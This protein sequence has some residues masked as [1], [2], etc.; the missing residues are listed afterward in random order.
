[1]H[2][3]V[4]RM[5]ITMWITCGYCVENTKN[6]YFIRHI[7]WKSYSQN[8]SCIPNI[9]VHIIWIQEDSMLGGYVYKRGG[10]YYLNV[11]IISQC[12]YIDSNFMYQKHFKWLIQIENPKLCYKE[13]YLLVSGDNLDISQYMFAT[14]RNKVIYA[15]A[16][17]ILQEEIIWK[18]TIIKRC[19]RN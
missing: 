2:I 6:P 18:K 1:M 3:S 10:T 14:T 19:M 15:I 12:R 9:S 17:V 7:M 4:W 16:T 5:W 13:S 11:V 8:T